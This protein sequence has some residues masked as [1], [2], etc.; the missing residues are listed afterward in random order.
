MALSTNATKLAQYEAARRSA[1]MT[2]AANPSS[3]TTQPPPVV[4]PESVAAQQATAGAEAAQPK[5]EPFNAKRL[6]LPDDPT[7]YDVRV[8]LVRAMGDPT[9][10]KSSAQQLFQLHDQLFQA[11]KAMMQVIVDGMLM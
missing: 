5:E 10:N 1:A 3:P 9:I 11:E 6:V 8:S 7:S 2:G 4:T